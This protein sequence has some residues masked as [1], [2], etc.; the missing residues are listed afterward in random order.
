MKMRKDVQALDQHGVR[1]IIL[2]RSILA[3]G[4]IDCIVVA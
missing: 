3:W 2:V 4:A 1:W